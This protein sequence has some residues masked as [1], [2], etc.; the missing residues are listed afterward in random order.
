MTIGQLLPP[1]P[2]MA[3]TCAY[4]SSF[5]SARTAI[6]DSYST[7][8]TLSDSLLRSITVNI[9]QVNSGRLAGSKTQQWIRCYD[10]GFLK[11]Q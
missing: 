5:F 8:A 6:V 3:H 4:D 10:K 11:A 9:I 2:L 7:V 1:L